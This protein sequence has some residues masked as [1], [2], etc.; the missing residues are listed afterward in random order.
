NCVDVLSLTSAVHV[1]AYSPSLPET[2]ARHPPIHLSGA[3]AAD[4]PPSASFLPCASVSSQVPVTV[5]A[6][7]RAAVHV[8]IR[9]CPLA[10]AAL[11][12]P[13]RLDGALVAVPACTVCAR[14]VPAARHSI[15]T[16]NDRVLG[17]AQLLAA[18]GTVVN[19]EPANAVEADLTPSTRSRKRLVSPSRRSRPIFFTM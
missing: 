6:V 8:P 15:P 14:D 10:V 5:P 4:Q 9:V 12:E 17:T 7:S 1:P 3:F 2:T 13:F 16:R 18:L 11:H 19:G